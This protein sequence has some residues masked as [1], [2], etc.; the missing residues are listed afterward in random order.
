[1]RVINS[2]AV[3][4]ALS[5]AIVAPVSAAEFD[6]PFVGAQ[7]GWQSEK[8]RDTESSFG[9][10]PIDDT[11]NSVTAGIYAGYDKHVAEK[12]VIGA[13]AGLDFASD[14]EAQ[15]S[16]AGTT[17]SVDPKYS[18]DL[19]ARAGL[20]MTPDTLVYARG[21]YTNARVRTTVDSPIGSQSDSDNQDGWLLGGG[22]ERQIKANVSARLEYRHSQFSQDGDGK[23]NRNRVLAGLAYRF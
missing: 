13:E 22:I 1:L 9:V 23:D 3:A 6:G 19:T 21:G 20:L 12:V 5:F 14:D 10:V 16:A 18:F 4:T 8:M 7:V 17:F 11:V 15:T 2:V